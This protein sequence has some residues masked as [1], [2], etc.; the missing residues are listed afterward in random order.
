MHPDIHVNFLA[1]IVAVVVSFVFSFLWHGPLFGKKWCSLMGYPTDCPPDKKMMNKALVLQLIGTF[2]TA[3]CLFHSLVVWR[4]SVWGVGADQP[5]YMYGFFAGFFT[6]L[7]FYVPM[8]LGGVAWERKPWALFA[9]NAAYAFL[10]LQ[11]IGMVLAF[12]H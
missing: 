5:D 2:L 8:L 6:W 10:N 7:G 3:F 11:L 12:M 9:L 4:P 1:I